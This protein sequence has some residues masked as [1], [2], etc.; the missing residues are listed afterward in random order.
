MK[1]YAALQLTLA[2]I[3]TSVYQ[4]RLIC[5]T[6]HFQQNTHSLKTDE[7]QLPADASEINRSSQLDVQA[8]A[9]TGASTCCS[10]LH[11]NGSTAMRSLKGG[12]AW[13]AVDS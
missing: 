2:V 10:V 9:G 6:L 7:Y 11:R 12:F 4:G 8:N 5:R 13:L 3:L 1:R